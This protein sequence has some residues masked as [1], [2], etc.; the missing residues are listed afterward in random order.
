MTKE[1]KKIEALVYPNS[2]SPRL[3]K[4]K[5]L[6]FLTKSHPAVIFGMYIIISYFLISHYYN[7][8]QTTVLSIIGL[9]LLGVFAWTLA[10]Y[11][12]HR[13]L[14][15]KIEDATY[16]SGI[17]YLFHGI[18]HEYPNDKGRLVLP[19]IPSLIIA[20]LFFGLFYL[21]MRKYAF[22]FAP[23][24][25]MGYATYMTIHYTI[26]VVKPP[27]KYD[28]WWRLHNIHHYQQHDRAFGVSSPL[29]DI[30]F[31]TMPEKGRKTVDVIIKKK[32]HEKD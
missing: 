3:F 5:F 29:W 6:E 2:D 10:E 22:V 25:V 7:H 32:D 28:F 13:F 23:G 1:D 9:F 14:Y 26:H 4:N 21:I 27:K 11:L 12:M 17:Q 30:I 8:Y 15:H 31:G 18:H 19:V 24:F 16:N 20:A